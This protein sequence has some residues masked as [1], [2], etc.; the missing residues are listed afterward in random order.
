MK[1][2]T[3]CI[4]TYKRPITLRRCI[5]SIMSQVEKFDLSN[6]VAIYVANDASPDDTASVLQGY[7]TL[8]YFDGVSREKNL[9]M[10]VNIKTM[11]IE[12]AEKSFYQ[13]IVTDDDYLQPDILGELADFLR[14]RLSDKVR[15]AAIWTPRFSYLENG[16]LH[17]VVCNSF[18]DSSYIK[19]STFNVGRY[20]SNG[21]VL[22]G[23]ILSAKSIDFEFWEQYK[24]NAFFP[25]I[26]L[27]DLLFR[28][29]AYYWNRNVVHHTVLNECHWERWGKNDVVIALRLLMDYVNAFGIMAE[30]IGYPAKAALFYCMSFVNIKDRVDYFLCSEKVTSDK[31]M[32][33]DA[34]SEMK[35]QGAL[36]INSQLRLLMALALPVIVVTAFKSLLRLQIG[37]LLSGSEKR[38]LRRR[39]YNS[40]INGLRFMPVALKVILP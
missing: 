7:R 6:D 35:A 40:R 25:M 28:E 34:I 26:F 2:L 9:G 15:A 14:S 32:T 10:N 16:N 20:M 29:G 31:Q 23:L 22:S 21:F 4:P 30:K 8:S 24:E 27:G 38:E 37:L 19:P 33:L 1:L 12:L 13:L 5:D 17:C 11:L 36:K 39:M 18:K 3:I